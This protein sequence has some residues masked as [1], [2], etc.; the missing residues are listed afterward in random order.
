MQSQDS[1]A[2]ILN[3]F[4]AVIPADSSTV[5]LPDS[6]AETDKGRGGSHGFGKAALKLQTQLDCSTVWQPVLRHLPELQGIDNPVL[7]QSVG[8]HAEPNAR[9]APAVVPQPFQG[10]ADRLFGVF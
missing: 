9:R 3:R 5:N 1:L 10:V 2:P 6:E 4:T 7:G 8:D